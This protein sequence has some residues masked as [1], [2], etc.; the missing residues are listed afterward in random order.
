MKVQIQNLEIIKS[1]K[2]VDHSN[3][4]IIDKD[5]NLPLFLLHEEKE[6]VVITHKYIKNICPGNY[7]LKYIIGQHQI[8]GNCLKTYCRIVDIVPAK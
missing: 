7:I 1:E 4:Q 5:T 8:E 3:N 2:L 6:G